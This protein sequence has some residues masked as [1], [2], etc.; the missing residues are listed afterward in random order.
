MECV[1]ATPILVKCVS[2]RKSLVCRGLR[3]KYKPATAEP[4]SKHIQGK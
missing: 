2:F 1:N 3:L 4:E